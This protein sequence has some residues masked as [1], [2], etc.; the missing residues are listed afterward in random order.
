M[1]FT[2]NQIKAIKLRDRDILVSAAAGS[3]KTSVLVER[4]LER[5][6]DD[7]SRVDVDRL[8][9]MTFTKA[10]AAEMKERI[11]DAIDEKIDRCDRGECTLGDEY[12]ENLIRQS[13]LV[14]NARIT[15]IHGFCQSVIR[16]HFE[17]IGID[18][19]FRVGDESEC[20]LMRID[21][22]DECLEEAYKSGDSRFFKAVEVFSGSKNDSALVEL[23]FRLYDYS[24]ACPDP[25]QYLEKCIKR[26][27]ADSV[28]DFA[29]ADFVRE[30]LSIERAKL[31]DYSVILEE[32]SSL[33]DSFPAVEAY[34]VSID[35]L[36][37]FADFVQQT[38][39]IGDYDA[40]AMQLNSFA[41]DRLKPVSEK[42]LSEE[43]I[44][45]KNRV[46]DIR[47]AVKKGIDK[48]AGD[49]ADSLEESYRKMKSCR[50]EVSALCE[51]TAAFNEKYASQ[52][53]EKNI[54][55][56]ND[57]EHMAILI[58][59]KNPEIS[60][61]YRELFD[62][63]YIDEYQDS[64][65]TQERLVELIKREDGN[66]F[67]VGDVKQ[68]IYRFRMAR[69]DLFIGKFETY[70]DEESKQQRVILNDNFRSRR[71]VVDAVNEIFSVIMRKEFG[72]VEY[73]DKARLNY[74]A[75]YYDE[76]AGG[77]QAAGENQA[78][79]S[80]CGSAYRAEII[81]G[82]PDELSN[83]EFEANVIAN[84][85]NEMVSSHMQVY[86][87]KLKCM[88]SVCYSDFVILLRA[89]KGWETPFRDVLTSAGIPVSVTGSEGYF[90]ALE[91][92]TAL[93]FL[94]IVDN[95]YQ[96][97]PFAT[98]MRSP[99]GG[100]TDRELGEVCALAEE[101][102][103]YGKVKFVARAAST[104]K[105]AD[106]INREALSAKCSKILT[107]ISG[108]RELSVYKS[109]SEILQMFIDEEYGDYVRT[110]NKGD[111]RMANLNMLLSRAED[112]GK[113]SFKGLY[114]FVRY[115]DQIRKYEMDYGEAGVLGEGD[116]VVR[117]MTIH[118]SKGLEFPVCFVAG[119]E[120]SR[121]M[122]DE[123]N[124]VVLD[125]N[126]GLGCDYTDVNKRI[127]S[128]TLLKSMIKEQLSRE[129]LAE[130]MRILYVAMT[131]AREKLIMVGTYEKDD[132]FEKI[133]NSISNCSS[134]LN[135]LSYSLVGG[136]R[137]FEIVRLDEE[138]IIAGRITKE[139]VNEAGKES[140][141]AILRK[142]LE[143]SS[144]CNNSDVIND[145]DVSKVSDELS[146]LADR[147]CFKY[148]YS[149]MPQSA[150]KMSVS[151]LKHRAIE[152]KR[153]AGVE[154]V[155]DGMQLF[156]ETEPDKYIPKFMR[157]KGQTQKGGTFYGTAFH[158][159]L[160][161][162][163]YQ[164]DIVTPEDV[165]AFVRK[166]RDAYRMDEDQADAVNPADVAFFLNSDLGKRMKKAKESGNLFREQPFVFGMDGILIQG[167][168]DAY[169]VEEDGIT[170][171]DYKTDHVTDAD[172]L[173]SRY[174]TQLEYYGRALSQITWK[175]IKAL[176]IYSSRLREEIVL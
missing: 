122:H 58:L 28:E 97:I 39:E 56:F 1:G 33:I 88:R 5:I 135:M 94:S 146:D 137:H 3:G 141:Y 37:D 25:S 168:I 6:C 121:N 63:I 85:I 169:I 172:M 108:Y 119:L 95:P 107:L 4:I 142:T 43:E 87:K 44:C 131:R 128:G 170:I 42:G 149:D 45:A 174:R 7:D 100:F 66:V 13:I 31:K 116:N 152:A 145:A 161:L 80:V 166:M 165:S 120:K 158:R 36:S 110:M 92:Q 115:M 133:P 22:L 147:I 98:L 18:P 50:E 148:P 55:D 41:P 155:P 104:E 16:D 105:D 2:D 138:S 93:A 91:V 38:M 77:K 59:S 21:A 130:E 14:H 103:L 126:F 23:I 64:N 123:R 164:T 49:F 159:I 74:G 29:N 47:D 109:V 72:N 96:D 60:R 78:A 52:K 30:F 139:I 173:I 114:H 160:E 106:G 70:T 157:K 83:Q 12:R 11:R 61:A 112:F 68:S 24:Q 75:T 19:N 32:A 90:S 136:N 71:E 17:E 150:A 34:R 62:E 156:P 26:Y 76:A 153:A 154:L 40:V 46:K 57:M 53:R 35:A 89:L 65:L 117:I 132:P 82:C 162:W 118:K 9:I 143:T 15:T 175:R 84:R 124:R 10:A 125:G 8:L 51:L 176:T 102:S 171:I 73:D 134:F 81:I 69:P 113:T 163:E 79:G 27:S 151:E 99:V 129:N 20:K 86:D 140:I 144:D 127:K 48:L 54:I 111:R 67:C 167:I 101:K